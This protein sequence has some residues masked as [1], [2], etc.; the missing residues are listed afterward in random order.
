M[1]CILEA[2]PVPDITWH[3]A[4]QKIED[5]KRTKMS[6][7]AISKDTYVLILEIQNPT[8]DDGGNYRCNAV[9]MYG[10]SNAN[11]ALNFQGILKNIRPLWYV[12]LYVIIAIHN[13]KT[14]NVQLLS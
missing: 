14:Q 5:S 6:R 12:K 13:L 9:N 8:K 7:K 4:D 3:C 10:E 2:H 1:E 11:I